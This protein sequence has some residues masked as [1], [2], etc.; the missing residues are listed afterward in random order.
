M[1]FRPWP[2]S[3]HLKHDVYTINDAHYFGI[4]IKKTDQGAP[5][6]IQMTDTIK[7]FYSKLR[8]WVMSDEKLIKYVTEKDVDIRV[9]YYKRDDLPEEV[10]PKTTYTVADG[11]LGKRTDPG[12]DIE[13]LE[14]N[15]AA[16]LV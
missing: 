12:E 13:D 14:R 11:V 5:E 1:E 3:Y 4:R 10:R 9:H 2:R 8:D 7:I 6:K 15:V 16:D